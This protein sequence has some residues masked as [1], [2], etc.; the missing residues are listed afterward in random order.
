M[1]GLN[2]V[3]TRLGLACMATLTVLILS[4]SPD[5]YGQEDLRQTPLV[6]AIERAKPSVVNIHSE[7]TLT[8]PDTRFGQ[9]ET[10]RRVNGMGTGVVFDPRGYIITNQHVIDGVEKIRVTLNDKSVHSA[11]LV[12][13]DRENDLAVIKIEPSEPMKV[14]TIGTSEDL[15]V[16]E[17][18][19][20]VGNAYGYD[21]TVTQGIISSLHRDVQLNDSQQYRD[22]IQT[23]A[24]IN[25]GNSG[26]PLLN[27]YGQMI[28][29]NVAVRAEAQ[30]IGF[31]IP[32]DKVLDVTAKLMNSERLSGVWHGIVAGP[33]PENRT[34]L[35]VA[36]VK[37][38]S[39]AEAAGLAVGDLIVQIDDVKIERALDL[40]RV[41]IDAR[42][43]QSLAVELERGEK[44]VNVSMRLAR[45]GTTGDPSSPSALSWEILGMALQTM[46]D[47]RFQRYQT[48]YNGGLLITSVRTG[49]PAFRQGIRSGDVLVGLHKWETVTVN[50][51]TTILN[52]PELPS[53]MP[54]KFYVLRNGKTLYGY[55][56]TEGE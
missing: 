46:P 7:K 53:I 31:A 12:S 24:S 44:T 2:G 50:D 42:P 38:G 52:R 23:D 11:K 36:E 21:Y 5:A 16:A 43:G 40:E 37:S 49:G 51:V 45:A 25:P 6:R 55:L 56:P 3:A 8:S 34:G 27:A 32:V 1:A 20:A 54:L 33:T 22:L 18:V 29:I 10:S 39:P 48:R 47:D 19:L 9:I 41:L 35:L 17:P 30:G 14:I 4:G 28:G 26:G 13:F 15:M